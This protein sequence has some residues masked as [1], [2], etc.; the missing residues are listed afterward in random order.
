MYIYAFEAQDRRKSLQ[1]TS[2]LVAGR[3]RTKWCVGKT[4]QCESR[5]VS[6][7]KNFPT[8]NTPVVIVSFRGQSKVWN[9]E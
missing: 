4:V 1:R 6:R 2:F 5:N 9:R 3:K 7:P 8:I